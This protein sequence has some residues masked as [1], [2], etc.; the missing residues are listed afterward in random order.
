MQTEKTKNVLNVPK[1]KE[2]EQCWNVNNK[3]IN[4]KQTGCR[5]DRSLRS[6]T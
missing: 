6:K 5:T 1:M 3:K 4:E 2:I